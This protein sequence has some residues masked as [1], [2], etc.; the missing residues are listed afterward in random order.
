MCFQSKQRRAQ[1]EAH[2]RPA[3]GIPLP[4]SPAARRLPHLL[5]ELAWQLVLLQEAVGH[6]VRVLARVQ[7]QLQLEPAVHLHVKHMVPL[8]AQVPATAAAHVA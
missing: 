7:R 5:L 3:R 4:L 1:A 8:T 6:N 2:A